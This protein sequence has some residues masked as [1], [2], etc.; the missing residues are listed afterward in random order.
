MSKSKNNYTDP[1]ILVEKYGVDAL[2]FYLMSSSV[3]N[4]EDFNF[5]D[6]GV[7]EIYKRVILILYNTLR[8]YETVR[9]TEKATKPK[10]NDLT[11]MWILSRIN[12]F[13]LNLNEHLEKYN[14]IKACNEIKVFAEDL[15]TWYIRINRER[16][17]EEKEAR[18]TLRY[19]L[20]IFSKSI[21]PILPFV[22]EKIYQT[23]N[24]NKKSVHLQEYPKFDKKNVDEKMLIKMAYVRE[25]V[26][27]GLRERDKAEIGLRWPLAKATIYSKEHQPLNELAEI[28]KSQLNIKDFELKIN[29]EANETSVELDTTL[30]PELE[31]EGYSRELSRQVQDF[32][33]KLG[34]QK[35]DTIELFITI[36]D[37]FKNVLETQKNFIKQRTNSKKMEIE[38]KATE[39]FKNQIEFKIKDKR[40]KI[41]IIAT[42]R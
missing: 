4:A 23:L 3:M 29:H 33:K 41:A 15:S 7:D 37:K 36:D 9:K 2:R 32:R 39:R 21:A 35:K 22:S 34:L 16:F 31:A 26:S 18:E 30:T 8:F 19:V 12:Q 25:I 6:K 42:K 1:M 13:G 24:G 20:E 17:E 28:I 40:G 27:L 14:T 38:T 11:D 5:S 10:K